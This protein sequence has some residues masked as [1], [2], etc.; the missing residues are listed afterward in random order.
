MSDEQI[1]QRYALA[2]IFFATNSV[3][4]AYTEDEYGAGV[5]PPEWKYK[6]GWLTH[7]SECGWYG[8]TCDENGRILAIDLVSPFSCR[9]RV[10][11]LHVRNLSN[12]RNFSQRIA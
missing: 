8:I 12:A 10:C 9:C 7:E 6:Y 5:S 2:C 11:L 4:T 3:R 1:I